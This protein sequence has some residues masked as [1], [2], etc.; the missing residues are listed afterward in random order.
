MFT[1]SRCHSETPMVLTGHSGET[2][3]LTVHRFWDLGIIKKDTQ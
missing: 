1:E 3:N 2:L